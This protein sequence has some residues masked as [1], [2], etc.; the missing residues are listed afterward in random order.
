MER[1]KFFNPKKSCFLLIVI[2]ML[3]LFV[4]LPLVS[5]AAVNSTIFSDPSNNLQVFSSGTGLLDTN[6]GNISLTVSGTP[7]EALLYVIQASG[8]S[9]PTVKFNNNRDPEVTLSAPAICGID[10]TKVYRFNLNLDLVVV[11]TNQYSIQID[12]V[13]VGSINGAGLMVVASDDAFE[14]QFTQ[15]KE[16]C[17]VFFFSETTP[18]TFNFEPFPVNRTGKVTMFV[19]DAQTNLDGRPLRTD[20]VRITV[21]GSSQILTNVFDDA[22]GFSWSTFTT[23]V[24]IPPNATSV[25][26]TLGSAKP[27]GMSATLSTVAFNV[28]VPC[29]DPSVS[30]NADPQA[31]CKGDSTILRWNSANATSISIEPGVG[32]NLPPSGSIEVFPQEDTTYTITASTDFCGSA[33]DSVTVNVVDC[34]T[35]PFEWYKSHWTVI[36]G[37]DTPGEFP[38]LVPQTLGTPVVYTIDTLEDAVRF[39]ST[40]RYEDIRYQMAQELLI[41]KFNVTLFKDTG[42]VPFETFSSVN[43]LINE[44]DLVLGDPSSSDAILN[45]FKD[46]LQRYN[47]SKM[48]ALLPFPEPAKKKCPSGDNWF[49]W[50]LQSRVC[51]PDEGYL[52]DNTIPF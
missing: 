25:S 35:R 33:T 1:D 24:Q 3:C 17:D 32:G 51:Y 27:D 13:P 19:G 15:I 43:A 10:G 30:I 6:T 8:V 21:N 14:P 39:I 9:A 4:S 18:V 44:A 49:F 11:G 48:D 37:C 47:E 23:T 36:D 40:S 22:D 29:D 42:L 26:F 5:S 12:G 2:G 38:S 34:I 28:D 45:Q 31:I 41:A 16:G 52:F 50:Y 20:F 7:E 46:T